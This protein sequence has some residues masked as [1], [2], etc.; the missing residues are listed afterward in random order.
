[1]SLVITSLEENKIKYFLSFRSAYAF[2]TGAF[3]GGQSR[4]YI[5]VLSL[6]GAIS[7]FE[8]DSH[9]FTR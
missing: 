6:D 7:I 9:S 3:G 5:A 4:E 8:Q 1:M 2:V